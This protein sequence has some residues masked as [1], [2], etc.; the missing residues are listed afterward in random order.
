MGWANADLKA[1]P[2][3]ERLEATMAYSSG[4]NYIG[5][6]YIASRQHDILVN[7]MPIYSCSQ[8]FAAIPR[9]LG[10]SYPTSLGPA[11]SPEPWAWSRA[12]RPSP[13]GPFL[14]DPWAHG[15]LMWTP[16][17]PIIPIVTL[18]SLL[19]PHPFRAKRPFGPRAHLGPE[20]VWAQGPFGP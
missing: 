10:L 1:S 15:P 13:M 11:L 12:L 18:V 14:G 2:S 17:I 6:N 3:T 7:P 16:Y 5:H 19:W 4:H 8:T 20:P 9:A